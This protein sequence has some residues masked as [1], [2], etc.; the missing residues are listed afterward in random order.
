VAQFCIINK[1]QGYWG[2]ESTFYSQLV[3]DTGS[4]A[5]TTVPNP[6]DATSPI[7]PGSCVVTGA[8]ANAPLVITGNE[9]EDI[10]IDVSLSI[11]KSFEWVD[12]YANGLWE[13][14]K[15]EYVVDMGLRGMIPTV[16]Q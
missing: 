4:A 13:P 3:A 8:F 7:P 2:F 12:I 16:V 11:N 14:L 9:T 10:I 1:K 5:G 6:I 15:G